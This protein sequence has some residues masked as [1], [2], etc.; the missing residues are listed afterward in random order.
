MSIDLHL[1][2]NKTIKKNEIEKVVS[3]LGFRK[4]EEIEDTYYWFDYDYVSTRGCMFYL[5]YDNILHIDGKDKEFKTVCSTNT[6]AGRSHGD[7]QKQIDT[8]K[9]LNNK[10]GGIVYGDEGHGFFENDIPKLSR[11]DIACGFAYLRFERNL[12][13]V[14]Q[15]MEDVDIKR[16][17][18]YLDL[19]ILP[20][21]EKNFLT[22][23][24]LVPYFVSI[25]EDFLKTFIYRYI[26][27]NKESENL[28]YSKK[29][30]L[31][32]NIVKELVEKEKSIIDIEIEEYSFQNFKSANRAFTKYIGLDLFTHILNEKISIDGEEEKLIS[33]LSQLIKERHELIHEAKLNYNLDKKLIKSYYNSLELLGKT[34]V[35]VFKE[36]RSIRINLEE[37]L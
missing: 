4:D 14:K 1:L 35:R 3:S 5:G 17:H 12:V 25:M 33:I 28:I 37:E 10:F 29:E 13:M 32:Y 36:K 24:L 15:L 2:V 16:V 11:T 27:T 9:E 8:I 30:T 21:G 7:F 23:N 34:F 31:P 20:Y 18:N 22:N 6:K 26:E 19:G